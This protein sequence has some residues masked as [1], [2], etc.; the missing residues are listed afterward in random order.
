MKR[1]RISNKFRFTVFVTVCL[2]I[3]VFVFGSLMG[4]FNAEAAAAKEYV[5]YQV[6]SGDTLWNIARTFGP[7]DQDVRVTISQI[8]RLNNVNAST[9]QAGQIIQVPVN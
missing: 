6:K 9:L 5:S 4:L 8:C 7:S 2:L 1:Y 3:S